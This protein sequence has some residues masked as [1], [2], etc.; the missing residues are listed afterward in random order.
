M[1]SGVT[2]KGKAWILETTF[3]KQMNG[4]AT[5]DTM[6]IALITAATTPNANHDTWNDL[7]SAEIAT[8]NG[9]TAGGTSV[10]RGTT[11]FDVIS[12]DATAESNNY[13]HVQI[14]NIEWTASGGSIPNSGDGARYA[15]LMDN[16][17][18]AAD[19]TANKVIAWW[20]LGSDR[21]V[22]DGQ[23]LSLQDM[24]IRLS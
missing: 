7:H 19:N 18:S 10:T 12:A 1:A 15:V 14:K 17:G 22:S 16:A 9:Y 24:E 20:D 23:K 11:D 5:N 13:G 21:S 3:R 8:G 2:D 4:G 6:Y